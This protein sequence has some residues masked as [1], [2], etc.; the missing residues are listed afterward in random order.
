MKTLISIIFCWLSSTNAF[1]RAGFAESFFETPG[2]HTIC[3]CDPYSDDQLPVLSTSK[4]FLADDNKPPL[5]NVDKFYFYKNYVIGK[6]KNYFFIFDEGLEIIYTF[7]TREEW[8]KGISTKELNPIFTQW[9]DISDA[10]FFFTTPYNVIVIL[11][12]T[13]SLS[14]L[15]PIVVAISRKK[16]RSIHYASIFLSIL[17]LGITYLLNIYSF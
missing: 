17:A 9:L 12:I 2:G 1:S 5:Y 11:L 16:L 10:P 3:W 7:K 15:F 13:T 14:V 4:S 6:A 8:K